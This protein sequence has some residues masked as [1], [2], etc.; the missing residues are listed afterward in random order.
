MRC[1][2]PPYETNNLNR[3]VRACLEHRCRCRNCYRIPDRFRTACKPAKLQLQPRAS[4]L[5]YDNDNDNDND[6]M[7]DLFYS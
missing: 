1:A 5:D 3:S 7:T 2:Y 4:C 6:C